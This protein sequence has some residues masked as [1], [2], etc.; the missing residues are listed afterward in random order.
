MRRIIYISPFNY[1]EYTDTYFAEKK[2][3]LGMTFSKPELKKIGISMLVL[4]I[5]FFFAF[6]GYSIFI[7]SP[8]LG[9][10]IFF[11]IALAVFTGFVCHELAH[12]YTAQ[13]S[14]YWSEYQWYPF[15]L[16]LALITGFL[17]IVFAAPG[18]VMIGGP[19]NREDYG[20]TAAAGPLTNI[21]IAFLFIGL[22]FAF[23]HPVLSLIFLLTAKI[24]AFLGVFN[25]IPFPP[26]DGSKVV[27]WSIGH[28]IFIIILAIIAIII[29]FGLTSGIP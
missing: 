23:P 3:I 15:G 21:A 7:S 28:Y 25:L 6:N 13:K 27:S 22:M 17:G 20:K 24:N 4:T 2:R 1:Y 8:T 19:I 29:S 5:A 9:T 12:K 14:G 10:Y 16:L 26:L 18:A 11:G